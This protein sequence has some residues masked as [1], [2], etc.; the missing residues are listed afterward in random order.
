MVHVVPCANTTP[1]D[2]ITVYTK[3]YD[4]SVT[5]KTMQITFSHT[6]VVR[7]RLGHSNSRGAFQMDHPS[8]SVFCV[9]AWGAALS[10]IEGL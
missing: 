9:C 10:W 6:R 3:F 5:P 1:T 8:L 2:G 7:S 4:A